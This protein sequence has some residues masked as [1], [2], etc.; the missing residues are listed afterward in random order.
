MTFDTWYERH[1]DPGSTDDRKRAF[2]AWLAAKDFNPTNLQDLEY[3]CELAQL[4]LKNSEG[5]W[6]E[7]IARYRALLRELFGQMP[8]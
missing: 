8:G 2:V 6:P 5:I 3:I 4:Y 1:W 7:R